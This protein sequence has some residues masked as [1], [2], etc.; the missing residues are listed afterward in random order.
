MEGKGTIIPAESGKYPGVNVYN[1][2]NHGVCQGLVLE[3]WVAL[4]SQL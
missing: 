3:N 4:I 1:N 2:F